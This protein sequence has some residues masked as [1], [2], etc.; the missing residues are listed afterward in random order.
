M[1]EIKRFIMAGKLAP[2][3]SARNQPNRLDGFKAQQT[4]LKD[5]RQ[6]ATTFLPDLRASRNRRS[7][8]AGNPLQPSLRRGLCA[9]T[10]RHFHGERHAHR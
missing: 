9:A 4:W 6:A 10:Q 5:V 8:D 7:K 1:L 2:L 3:Q